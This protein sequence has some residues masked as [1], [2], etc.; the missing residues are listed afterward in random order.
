MNVIEL[1]F[2]VLGESLAVDHGYAL[3][4]AISRLV[5][6]LHAD[7]SPVSIG[8]IRGDYAGNGRLNL[9]RHSVLRLR[10]PTDLVPQLLL[11]AGK[12][13]ELDGRRV[14]LG[15][16]QIRA[17]IPAANLFARIVTIKVSGIDN[18]SPEHFLDAV[19][20]RLRESEIDGEPHLPTVASGPHTGQPR[21]RVL[22]LKER[23]L[24]GFALT[25]AGLSPEASFRLQRDS[26]FSRRRMGCGF[27]VPVEEG[28]S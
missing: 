26:P 13:L 23:R 17:I 20:R 16:P 3:Y 1:H 4:G 14:R 28:D 25:V 6:S 21:R 15:V 7:D 9:N 18:P 19:R 11:L 5:P 8:P 12:P 22:S 27:F 24:I 2:P 10:L